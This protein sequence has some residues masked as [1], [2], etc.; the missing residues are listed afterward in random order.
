[1][2]EESPW[3]SLTEAAQRSRLSREA[4]RARARRG[5]IPSR[6]SNRGDTLVQL[7]AELLSGDGQDNGQG[8]SGTSSTLESD[9]LAEVAELREKLARTES[10]LESALSTLTTEKAAAESTRLAEVAAKDELIAELKAMLAE[11][12]RP[13]WRKL[14]G[15]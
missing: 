7:P 11:A 5:L 14:V 8:M 12:R 9:L 15:G 6:K 10:R 13:W 3:L 1:M 4:V 2:A